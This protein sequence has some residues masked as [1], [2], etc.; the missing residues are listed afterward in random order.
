VLR[1]SETFAGADGVLIEDKGCSVAVHWR[2]APDLAERALGV[3]Q[4]TAA[5]L[6]REYRLQHGKAVA[7]ILP[8]SA[9][10]GAV[11]ELFLQHEPYR[12]RRPIFVGDDVTDE[13]GFAA[14][15]AQGGV[16]VRVGDGP[17]QASQRIASPAALR[18]ALRQWAA[19]GSV[20]FATA[21]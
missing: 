18:A 8:A 20:A 11:I 15:N 6:G 13:H 9:S 21:G 10:K 12:G 4:E 17:T 14:V 2:M 16:S 3:A 7:E 19:E 5:G 1:L